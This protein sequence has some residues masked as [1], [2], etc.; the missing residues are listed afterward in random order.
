MNVTALSR[1]LVTAARTRPTRAALAMHCHSITLHTTAAHYHRAFVT[2]P[3]EHS[4]CQ[5]PQLAQS[6]QGLGV[7]AQGEFLTSP[8]IVCGIFCLYTA[9]CLG[10]SATLTS[11]V[12]T[13]RCCSSSGVNVSTSLLNK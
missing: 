13:P 4:C 5:L 8:A 7:L 11:I 6:K 10:I 9:S 2:R 3:S 1:S 12:S